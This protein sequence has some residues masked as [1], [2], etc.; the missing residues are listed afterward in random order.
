VKKYVDL[1]VA[2]IVALAV[3]FYDVSLE[4]IA[5]LLHLLLETLH[6]MFE[7]LELAIEHTIEHAFHTEHH[8][9]QIIT[10]YIL[11]VLGIVL[12]RWLWRVVP[13]WYRGMLRVVRQTWI[14]RKIEME[15]YWL[16]L[17]LR[18]KITLI[19]TA[20]GVAYLASFF[21]M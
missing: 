16:S 7:F 13:D 9:S 3:V 8:T 6:N 5:E 4:L 21:V 10:F 1:L 15:I 20:L 11:V 14:R 18:Y 2:G 12:L 17:T 19:C